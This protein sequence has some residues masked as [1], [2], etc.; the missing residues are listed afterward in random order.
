MY[1]ED[2][3]TGQIKFALSSDSTCTNHLRSPGEG[4]ETLALRPKPAK[5]WPSHFVEEEL[6]E[7]P[8]WTQGQWEFLH[9]QGGI[10]LLKDNR[11]FKTFTARCVKKT[12]DEEKFLIYARSHCGE[13]HYKCVW[14]KNRGMN[15]LEFQVG[16]SIK[17]KTAKKFVFLIENVLF[18]IKVYTQVCIIT[19]HYVMKKTFWKELG[20]LKAEFKSKTRH[21]IQSLANT[22]E[23]SPIQ[24]VYVPS[25]IQ[26]VTTLK[27]CFTPSSTVSTDRKFLKVIHMPKKKETKSGFSTFSFHYRTRISLLGPMERRRIDLHIHAKARHDWLRMFCWPHYQTGRHLFERSRQ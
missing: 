24:M 2:E 1:T 7:L 19:S 21:R 16:K 18:F 12:Q 8:D 14:F 6:C 26:T 23:L 20:Q 27:S 4:Y 11:N 25:C 13:E 9:V 5:A 15:A 10:V 3:Y 17:V 22:L